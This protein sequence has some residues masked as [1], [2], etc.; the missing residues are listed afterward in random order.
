[1]APW[2]SC[3]EQLAFGLGIAAVAGEDPPRTTVSTTTGRQPASALVF[4]RYSS[5]R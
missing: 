4:I 3:P 2:L 5:V 1:V